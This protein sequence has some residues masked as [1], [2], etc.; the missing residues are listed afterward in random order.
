MG[1]SVDY[2]RLVKQAQLGDKQCID[3]LTTAAQERL[4][5]D[6]YRLTLEHDLTEDI[7]QESILEMLKILGELKE[8]DK[9]WPWLYKIALNK[10]RLNKRTQK[11]RRTVPLSQVY[12]AHE[13]K[14]GQEAMSNMVAE[15]LKEMV[16]KAMRKLRPQ[17]RAVLTMRC[18]RE[19]EYSLIAESL[20]CSE[21]AAKMMFYRAKK[22]LQKE[23]GS[24]GLG[25]GSFLMALI[26]FGKMTAPS[27][28]AAAKISVTAATAKV[29][30]GA[31]LAGLAGSKTGVV[32]L[33][34]AGLLGAGALV[35][36]SGPGKTM[37]V[38]G[39]GPSGNSRAA[40]AAEAP[41]GGVEECWYYF[42]ESADGAVMMRLM[43]TD[44]R[45]GQL[46]C[47]WRQNEQVNHRFDRHSGTV[48]IENHR[49]WR[50]DLAVMRLPTDRPQ[51]SKFLSAV[52]GRSGGMEYVPAKGKGILVIARQ[53]DRENGNH[54]DVLRH[55]YML[56]AECFL[57]DW[58][59]GVRTVD[60][61]DAMHKRGWTYFTVE[62]HINGQRVKGSGRLPFVYAAVE[63]HGPW[64]RLRI[65]DYR[66]IVDSGD[67][68]VIYD[69]AKAVESYEA[70]AFFKGLSR[71]WMGLHSIDTVRRDAAEEG[72]RFETKY[73]E[74][75]EK[76][77]VSLTCG[78]SRMLYTVDMETDVV[79]K[80][81]FA[82]GEEKT[83]ELMFS[84]VQDVSQ[85]GG[86][87]IEPQTG[88]SYAGN[89]GEEPGI[90]WL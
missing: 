21:L 6:V 58:P 67:A 53:N 1:N 71:P 56:E 85:A 2:V 49:M 28:A 12:D 20:G 78:Q 24:H 59:V 88:R 19:M 75:E 48:Y 18:Y 73:N 37:G 90:L 44:S 54:S 74:R 87:F 86:E 15:E 5:V 55:H 39:A 40:A 82:K 81:I 84:Y 46:Y 50:P 31:G 45:S 69:R 65:G 66:E 17:H 41:G 57:Y 79:Q 35:A 62:G 23:L 9:F 16:L 64:L 60:N 13:L 51:L 8:A 32:C 30:V 3:E 63:E 42:P 4:R 29:G 25:K 10:L 77:E 76:A 52:E 14:G 7:V 61:R 47:A 27:E 43:K 72:V 38:S 83:G 26:L 22:A 36:T 70:G 34:A 33:A 11:R 80:I 89:R 68:A